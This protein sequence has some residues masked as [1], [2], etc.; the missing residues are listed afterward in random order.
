M[1][2]TIGM[3]AAAVMALASGG[4]GDADDAG[5]A[6]ESKAAQPRSVEHAMATARITGTSERVVV[7]DHAIVGAPYLLWL[8]ARGPAT[9]A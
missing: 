4:C 6:A 3:L 2:G 8:L 5:S 7:L 9:T 1:R